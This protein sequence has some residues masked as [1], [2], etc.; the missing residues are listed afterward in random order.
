MK[1]DLI[2]RLRT[3]AEIRRQILTRKSVQNN[4][5]DRIS[6]LLEESADRIEAYRK[7]INSYRSLLNGDFT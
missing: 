5:P 4:E 2:E 7:L 1:D 3:R 6:D